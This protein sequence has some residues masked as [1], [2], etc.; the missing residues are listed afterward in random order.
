[1]AS[2]P[3]VR[4]L[5]GNLEPL[6]VE[7][8][9]KYGRD[10]NADLRLGDARLAAFACWPVTVELDIVGLGRTLF[11]HAIL[12]ADERPRGEYW[13]LLGAAVELRRTE[14][15]V[16]AAVASIRSAGGLVREQRLAEL[17]AQLDWEKL[18][19]HYETFRFRSSG[20]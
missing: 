9:T 12:A 20:A 11:C 18:A 8:S 7:A 17:L 5:R 6:V 10:W 2:R 13:A 14:Y 15:D 3:A 19:A 1:M 16:D 4:F